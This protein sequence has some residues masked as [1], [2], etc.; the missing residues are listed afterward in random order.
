M[1]VT[2]SFLNAARSL[3]YPRSP[4]K[5]RIRPTKFIFGHTSLFLKILSKLYN[6]IVIINMV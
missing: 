5:K 1:Q 2:E 6:N 3:R 4:F